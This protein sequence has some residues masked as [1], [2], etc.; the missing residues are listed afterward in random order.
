MLKIITRGQCF[1]YYVY[2]IYSISRE[3]GILQALDNFLAGIFL[4][5][6]MED[7]RLIDMKGN[8]WEGNR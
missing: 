2:I 7:G 1:W 3:L 8:R 6:S 4:N 5:R